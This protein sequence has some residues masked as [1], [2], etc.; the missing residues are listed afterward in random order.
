MNTEDLTART[1]DAYFLVPRT[2]DHPMH[3]RWLGSNTFLWFVVAPDVCVD[4]FSVSFSCLL[5]LVSR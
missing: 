3:M 2:F 4:S 1:T 5:V